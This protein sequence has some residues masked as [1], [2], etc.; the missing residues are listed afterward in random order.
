VKIQNKESIKKTAYKKL[1]LENTKLKS[2]LLK[3]SRE[4]E[5]AGNFIVSKESM[6][7]PDNGTKLGKTA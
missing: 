1:K 2:N 5:L 7:V 3:L 4:Y 6:Y